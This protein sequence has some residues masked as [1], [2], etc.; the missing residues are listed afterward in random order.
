MGLRE[1]PDLKRNR[2][3]AETPYFSKKEGEEGRKPFESHDPGPW[4]N[5]EQN[6]DSLEETPAKAAF[7]GLRWAMNSRVDPQEPSG[8][9]TR[10]WMQP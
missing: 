4:Q 2:K 8:G 5:L 1:L 10:L 9:E 7:P 6:R 3:R